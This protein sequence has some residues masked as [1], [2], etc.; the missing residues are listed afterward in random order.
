M[1][2]EIAV[3]N[4]FRQKKALLPRFQ[5]AFSLLELM[6]AVAVVGILAGLAFSSYEAY[7]ERAR[8]GLPL[9]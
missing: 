2:L 7:Y 8:I 5:T 6:L 3:Y 9:E 4:H 1:G